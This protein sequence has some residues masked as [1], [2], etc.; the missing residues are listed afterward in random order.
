MANVALTLASAVN[1]YPDWVFLDFVTVPD[2]MDV[3]LSTDIMTPTVDGV[4]AGL[5]ITPS[6]TLPGGV[7]TV[8]V[9]ASSSG[10]V[11][12]VQIPVT[13]QE[14]GFTLQASSSALTLVLHGTTSVDISAAYQFGETDPIDGRSGW[15]AGRP[16]SGVSTNSA[17]PQAKRPP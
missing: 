11:K 4:Q 2:G 8:T 12:E 15:D 9:S 14:P 5:M 17:S 7:Y 1:P 16:G 13:V 10:D 6:A 3:A